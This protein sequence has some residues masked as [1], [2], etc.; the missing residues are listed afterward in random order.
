MEDRQEHLSSSASGTD[1]VT[2][3]E[4]AVKK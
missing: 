3:I 1:R 2:Y 4:A